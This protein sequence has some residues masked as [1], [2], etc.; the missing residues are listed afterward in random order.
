MALTDLKIQAT[1][2]LERPQKLVDGDGLYLYVST[3]GTKSWRFD[4]AFGGKR[5]TVTIGKYPLVKLAAARIKRSEFKQ[6]LLDG[7]NPS[8]VKKARKEAARAEAE[9][10]FRGIAED[11][12][13]SKQERR[14][15]AWRQANRLYLDRDLFPTI[16]NTGIREINAKRLLELLEKCAAERGLKT[17][18]RV[19][20]TA[21]QVFEHAILRFKAELNPAAM[22]RRWAEIPPAKNRPHLLENEVHDLIEA[23]DSYPGY[24]TTKLAAKFLLLT[25]CRKTEV[26]EATW[27]EIDLA[28]AKWTIPANRMKM[29]DAHVVPLS[30]QAIALLENLKNISGESEYLFP[31]N[32]TAL[33]PISRTALNNMFA[34]MGS[35]KYKGRFS[36]HG[37]RATASTWLNERGYRADVIERQLAHTE[38]NQ[39]RASYNHAHYLPERRAMLQSWADFLFPYSAK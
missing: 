4:Y 31:K 1:K 29:K 27:T 32:S 6:M 12:Y 20:Q 23:I 24:I 9:D 15:D 3:A 33:K 13:S 22:L 10:T 14:S 28:N 38:R 18:D 8:A 25:F 17:A 30:S 5:C 16:G 26:T 11:W 34:T 39:I 21:L 7:I 35:E 36:P 37:I 2:P 19:R